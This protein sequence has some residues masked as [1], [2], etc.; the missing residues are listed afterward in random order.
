MTN[1][2]TQSAGRGE[3]HAPPVS[4]EPETLADLLAC[5]A[6]PVETLQQR[7]GALLE[8]MRRV[9]G[10]IPNSAAYLEI[11]PRALRSNQV[12]V[13]NF[14]NLPL[15]F[16]GLGAPRA[17]LGL[18]MYVSSRAAG[19]AYCSAHSCTFA[20]RRGA[21]VDE[22]ATAL[23]RDSSLSESDRAA[24]RVARS[25]G[26]VPATISD[27]ERQGIR[28]HFSEPNV[29]W[30]VLAIAMMGW[31]NKTMDALGMPLEEAVA[32]E[33]NDVISAA[34]WVPGKHMKTPIVSR[35]AP[36][37]DTLMAR[38]SLIRF[39]P[40]VIRLDRA[41]TAGVPDSWPAV[42]SYL[43]KRTGH[44][45]PLLSRLRHKRAIRAIATMIKDNFDQSE[46]VIGLDNKLAAGLVFVALVG[47]A[48]LE[49]DLRAA[50][51]TEAPPDSP[52]EYLVRTI[53]PSPVAIDARALAVA[54][55]IPPAGLVELV[56][57]I[58]LMQMLHRL[59]CFYSEPA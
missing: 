28:Q 30:I 45:F 59:S 13:P 50:G 54:K 3:G 5:E 25:L 52:L 42:G 35:Q 53:S 15:S 38:L 20:L 10:V 57:F 46:S 41:W 24:V 37:G 23:D 32:S 14:L 1:S 39:A 47:N 55:Q 22:V 2:G 58:S 49:R 16:W 44:A 29:E 12:M 4:P 21:T 27:K 18:V 40:Q 6:V 8:L 9:L 43:H 34:G 31:L 51:A 33:V 26:T 48:E 36:G 19:C 7:Y 11:W 56:T 17:T